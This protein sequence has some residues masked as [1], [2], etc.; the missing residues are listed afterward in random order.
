MLASGMVRLAVFY[1]DKR[2]DRLPRR[3]E[4]SGAADAEADQPWTAAGAVTV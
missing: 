4:R 1:S 3:G 2:K